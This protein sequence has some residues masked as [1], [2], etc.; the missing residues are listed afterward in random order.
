MVDYLS[1][2]DQS[3]VSLNIDVVLVASVFEVVVNFLEVSAEGFVGVDNSQA[4]GLPTDFA[5]FFVS[6]P[7]GLGDQEVVVDDLSVEV[8][9]RDVEVGGSSVEVEVHAVG[10]AGSGFP[11]AVVLVGVEGVDGVSPGLVETFDF[12]VVFLLAEG[13]DQILVLDGP[14]VS[15]DDFVAGRVDLV[16]AYVVGLGVVL[17]D[18]LASGGAE[19]KLG[20][21]G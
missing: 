4:R 9:R 19:V 5:S 21:A 2:F 12:V 14:A 3:Q 8:V 13:Q 20:D 18:D 16:D 17:A 6:I 1:D 15:E 7:L 11:G 10:L